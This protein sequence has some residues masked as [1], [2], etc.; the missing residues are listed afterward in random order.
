MT[1]HSIRDDTKRVYDY[2]KTYIAEQ[3]YPPTQRNIASGCFISRANVQRY[4]D[5]L[6][7][8]GYLERDEYT[9]RGIILGKRGIEGKDDHLPDLD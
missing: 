4:L 6:V 2:I 1:R 5:V 8:L 7:A 9:A 3:G